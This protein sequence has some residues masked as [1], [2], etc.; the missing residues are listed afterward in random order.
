MENGV[1]LLGSASDLERKRYEE[2]VCVRQRDK[3]H[4]GSF[5][6]VFVWHPQ[7]KGANRQKKM[8]VAPRRTSVKRKK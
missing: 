2:R 1:A 8:K 3:T 7:A 4:V 6:R 5:A